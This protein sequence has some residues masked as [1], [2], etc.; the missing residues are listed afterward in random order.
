[1][2]KLAIFAAVM[3]VGA[4]VALASTLNVPFFSDNSNQ[5]TDGF[6]G[7]KEGAGVDQTLTIIYTTVNNSDQVINQTV[8]F[9]LGANRSIKW[10]PV[11]DTATENK[12]SLVPNMTI[13][14]V[15]G[16]TKKSGSARILGS[17]AL[18]GS[19]NQFNSTSLTFA[20]VLVN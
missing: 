1:M 6:I 10:Q 17:A 8:T 16:T 11:Q 15:P 9:A 14:N 12:G 18:G 2:R 20:H 5:G 4:G 19:Y 13:E 7:V 3:V